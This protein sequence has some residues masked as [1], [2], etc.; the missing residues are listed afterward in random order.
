M[1]LLSLGVA[2]A[3]A[4]GA[5]LGDVPCGEEDET[6]AGPPMSCTVCYFRRG[7]P[8]QCNADCQKSV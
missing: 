7:Q 6:V 4:I 2:V 5:V 8:C 1:R 3:V